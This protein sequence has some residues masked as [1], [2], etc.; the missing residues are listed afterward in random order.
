MYE[1]TMKQL[2][3]FFCYIALFF[4]G[5]TSVA[6]ALPIHDGVGEGGHFFQWPATGRFACLPGQLGPG[7]YNVGD[8]VCAFN[9]EKNAWNSKSQ[10]QHDFIDDGHEVSNPVPTPLILLGTGLIGLAVFRRK[11]LVR[12]KKKAYR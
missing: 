2:W 12:P 9:I 6:V 8:A 11:K 1:G 10:Y 3:L 5:C 7:E 4:A